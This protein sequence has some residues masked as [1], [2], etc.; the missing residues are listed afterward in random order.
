ETG[1]ESESAST[2]AVPVQP[3]ASIAMVCFMSRATYTLANMSDIQ[4]SAPESVM[5]IPGILDFEWVVSPSEKRKNVSPIRVARAPASSATHVPPPI[6]V[7]VFVAVTLSGGIS[8]EV[9]NES[10]DNQTWTSDS[11]KYVPLTL[12]FVLLRVF[13]SGGHFIA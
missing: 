7:G 4:S 11:P 1:L 3:M 5:V 9:P 8:T 6:I 13:A 2:E 12:N 10:V